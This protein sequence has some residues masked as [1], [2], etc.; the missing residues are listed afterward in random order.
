MKER[1]D[2]AGGEK[3]DE[4]AE[5]AS[6]SFFSE[7]PGL[8]QP[9]PE[10]TMRG[11]ETLAIIPARGG[12]VGIPGKNLVPVGGI[13]LLARSIAAAR[14]SRQVTRVVV[15][16]DDPRIAAEAG[17]LGAEVVDRPSDLSGPR[18]SSESAL[19]QV[20]DRLEA[21]EGY[22]PDRVVFLQCT[23][24]LTRPE[25][26]DGTLERLETTGADSALTL[27]PFHS[28]LWK[29]AGD[30]DLTAINHEKGVRPRRQDREPQYRENGAVYVMRTGIFRETRSR[31]CGRTV[32][33]VVP[34]S[35]AHEI[36]E[37]A[38]L[39][40][41]EALVREAERET[42]LACLPAHPGAVIF[43]FDGV[44]TDNSVI[45]HGDGEE[46]I[47][48]SRGDGMGIGL[49]R[50]AYSGPLQVLSKE[51]NPIL[52]Q[53][54]AKLKLP[55]VHGIDDKGGYLDRWSAEEGIDLRQAIYLGNDVNDIPAL[56]RVG[57]PVVVADAEPGAIPHARLVLTRNGGRGAVRELCDLI[58]E[59]LRQGA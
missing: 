56:R 43:D 36:D 41:A 59:R 34:E 23:S 6:T 51:P 3:D 47:V 50:K 30:G 10:D 24:P 7:R 15:S 52:K 42:R 20:L 9:Q 39:A 31:F 4:R 57:C 29:E 11:M 58:V 5:A 13:S 12:S 22:Q 33:Y 46:S 44:F 40:V 18:A 25:D 53:R 38:D 19:L 21:S 28:F 27:A 48:C 32:G 2:R 16:T 17:R 37:P 45:V 26:I 54:C 49:L 55:C 1:H 35:R 8:N 14:Q